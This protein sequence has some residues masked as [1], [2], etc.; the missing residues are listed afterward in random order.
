MFDGCSSLKELNLNNFNTNN[1]TDMSWMFYK[2]SSLKE[3]NFN[4]FNAN[5][6]I[7]MSHMFLG[8]SYELKIKIK[9]QYKNIKE[10][11]YK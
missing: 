6:L 5:N 11:A 1:V 7:D 3:L 8:C 4:N 2:C 9:T 10:E